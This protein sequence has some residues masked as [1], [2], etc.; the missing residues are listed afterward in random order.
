MEGGSE[1]EGEARLEE[2]HALTSA[3]ARAVVERR[4]IQLCSYRDL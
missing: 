2:L 1:F 3:E 4:G